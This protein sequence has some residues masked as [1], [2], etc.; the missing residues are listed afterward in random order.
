MDRPVF[1]KEDLIQRPAAAFNELK[2]LRS[3]NDLE[4]Q[5]YKQDCRKRALDAGA[6][7]AYKTVSNATSDMVLKEA[8]IFYQWLIKDI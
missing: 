2:S 3:K 1:D 7:N 5:R 6:E 8:E 4:L